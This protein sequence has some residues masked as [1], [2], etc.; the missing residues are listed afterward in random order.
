MPDAN[1]ALTIDARIFP[2]DYHA[3]GVANAEIIGLVQYWN[4]SF[5]VMDGKWN[6]PRNPS[7]GASNREILSAE[8]WHDAVTLNEWHHI[9]IV[10]EAGV[11]S[12]L[13]DGVTLAAEPAAPPI[14]FR[15][16]WYLFLGRFSGDIDEVRISN[17]A[18]T[19]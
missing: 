14:D 19:D 16:P 8:A 2:R 12:V 7:V 5:V 10:F 18:R 9:R 13:I 4:S 11:V 15:G 17:I 1:A 6:Q 3:W